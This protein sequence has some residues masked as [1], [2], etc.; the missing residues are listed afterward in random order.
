MPKCAQCSYI[1]PPQFM[2][3]INENEHRC[4]FCVEDKNEITYG[5]DKKATRKEIADDYVKFINMVR[6]KN[7]ILKDAI[8]GDTSDVPEK[9]IV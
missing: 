3:A 9:L 5:K 7:N 1:L 8:K 4:R 6:E 2:V